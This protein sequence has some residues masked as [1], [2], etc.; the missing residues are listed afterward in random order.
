M[1]ISHYEVKEFLESFEGTSYDPAKVALMVFNHINELQEKKEQAQRDRDRENRMVNGW[2][3]NGTKESAWAT[4]NF[5]LNF[6]GPSEDEYLAEIM[7]EH[8]PDVSYAMS[9]A[10]EAY[11]TPYI[12]G[13]EFSSWYKE[14]G[15]F[16][17]SIIDGYISDINWYEL[18]ENWIDE[19]EFDPCPICGDIRCAS[20]TGGSIEDCDDYEECDICGDWECP[21][22]GTGQD[23]DCPDYEE[24]VCEICG[25][26]TC[27]G[28]ADPDWCETLEE[29]EEDFD[30]NPELDPN[31]AK[32]PGEMIDRTDALID[33]DK[34]LSDE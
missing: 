31:P 27:D 12:T 8:G 13:E 11:L 10:V 21:S 23:S 7:K 18:C 2:V 28:K 16:T 20:Q 14:S 32:T 9:E 3:G 24:P 19:I 33:N 17:Q 30:K 5:A 34:D 4:W 1:S 15:Y 29:E 25:S 22:L 26:D 6:S